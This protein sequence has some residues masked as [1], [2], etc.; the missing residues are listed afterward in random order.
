[1]LFR[2]VPSIVVLSVMLCLAPLVLA[3]SPYINKVYEFLPAP[4]QFTN[5]MPAFEEGDDAAAMCLKMEKMITGTKKQVVSLGAWGGYV[6]FGFDHMVENQSGKLDLQIWGNAFFSDKTNPS[7]GGS[8]EPGIVY[9]SY[10]ADGNGLPDDEWYELAGSEYSSTDTHR[11]YSVTYYRTPA[12]HVATPDTVNK[13]FVDT[14]F[15]RWKD[16]EGNEGYIVKNSF[17]KQAYYP[18]WIAEDSLVY[19]GT[20][21]KNNARLIGT[22]YVQYA[23]DYGYVDNYPNDNIHSKLNIDWAVDEDGHKVHLPGIHFVKVMTGMQQN[24]GMI[25]ES[26]T[27]VSGAADLHLTGEAEDDTLAP[28]KDALP[29]I[30]SSTTHLLTTQVYDKIII[31]TATVEA[32]QVWDRQGRL[33]FS[34][35]TRHGTTVLSCP[36]LNRGLYLIKIGTET[37]KFIKQ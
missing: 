7:G 1:M 15:V 32:V 37:F 12:D 22:T 14:T 27:E 21:L 36:Q 31:T 17:H 30:S 19:K 11:N 23:Y 24:C 18:E 13:A 26:S 16:N 6:V 25:G 35:N 20:R 3:Q 8:S 4:G 9:V 29:G 34:A 33:M 5:A 2:Y 28:V 10:D